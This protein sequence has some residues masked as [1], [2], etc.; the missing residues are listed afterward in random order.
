MDRN[1]SLSFKTEKLR[2]SQK[3]KKHNTVDDITVEAF[4]QRVESGL[5]LE[6]DMDSI[7]AEMDSILGTVDPQSSAS[8]SRSTIGI[9][10]TCRRNDGQSST[11]KRDLP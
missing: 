10:K 1:R 4:R 6:R 2:S 11:P 8:N 9:L 3:L 7:M 5:K